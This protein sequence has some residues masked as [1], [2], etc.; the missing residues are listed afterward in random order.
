MGVGVGPGVQVGTRVLVWVGRANAA[1]VAVV[2]NVGNGVRVAGAWAN[3]NPCGECRAKRKTSPPN[4]TIFT[5]TNIEIKM[6]H[7]WSL[8]ALISFLRL[9]IRWLRCDNMSQ[10]KGRLLVSLSPQKLVRQNPTFAL[11]NCLS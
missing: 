3:T 4:T 5:T 8:I 1:P 7:C 11:A 9:S 6:V 2:V 10:G